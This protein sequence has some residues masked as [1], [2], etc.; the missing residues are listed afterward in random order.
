MYS[1]RNISVC[2]TIKYKTPIVEGIVSKI[3][4]ITGHSKSE[5]VY[6]L[7]YIN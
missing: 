2:H 5:K 1:K 4:R 7:V 6:K 3:P